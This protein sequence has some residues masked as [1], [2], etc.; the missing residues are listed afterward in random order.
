MPIIKNLTPHTINILDED[1][2][3]IREFPSEGIAMISQSKE[4]LDELDLIQ[5][6]KTSFG[7]PV[8]LPDPEEGVVYIVSLATVDAAKAHGR[9]VHDLI[10]T[11]DPVRDNEGH[12]IGYRRLIIL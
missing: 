8:V 5:F 12:I 10:L 4:V 2:T 6:V 7:E 1:G 11:S 9:D 3:L